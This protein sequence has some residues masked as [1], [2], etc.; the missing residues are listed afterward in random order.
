MDQAARKIQKAWRTV[1]MMRFTRDM[2][3]EILVKAK[4][5]KETYYA[6]HATIIQCF[7]RT[8]LYSQAPPIRR[9]K[10]MVLAI[11]SHHRRK[12]AAAHVRQYRE[13][14]GTRLTRFV[15]KPYVLCPDRRGHLTQAREILSGDNIDALPP[16]LRLVSLVAIPGISSA[17][18]EELGFAVAPIQALGKHI[19]KLRKV[20]SIQR[21]WRSHLDRRE[22]RRRRRAAAKIQAIWRA[23]LEKV[24][25]KELVSVVTKLQ[26]RM[27][28]LLSMSRQRR[29]QEAE[30]AKALAAIMALGDEV[31]GGKRI[32]P[33][34]SVV[35]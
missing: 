23:Q 19:Y 4:L 17:Q 1:D 25:K 13:L 35:F 32:R 28:R 30:L 29:R 9:V 6:R 11:Q 2:A 22:R 5:M 12:C 7:Y 33:G 27:R 24:R 8:R 14:V 10:R 20:E 3:V 26:A 31:V 16:P 21:V 18:R 15:A 34:G